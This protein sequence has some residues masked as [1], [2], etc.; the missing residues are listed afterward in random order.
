M[1]PL[2][3]VVPART[4]ISSARPARVGAARMSA[5]FGERLREG[6]GHCAGTETVSALVAQ[7]ISPAKAARSL[8]PKQSALRRGLG[9]FRLRRDLYDGH[10]DPTPEELD[11]AANAGRWSKRP[12][13]LFLKAR[14]RR[15]R[16]FGVDAAQCFADVLLCL[17]RDPLAGVI[18]PP[19]IGTEGVIVR[20]Q[21]S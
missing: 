14:G 10:P 13:D 19:L 3:F 20:P 17:S 11:I 4:R 9:R 18:S 21:R 16:W 5:S 8:F 2:A 1:R 12:S 6:A 7:G 15:G